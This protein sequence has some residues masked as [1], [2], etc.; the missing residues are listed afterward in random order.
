M[1]SNCTNWTAFHG[2][3]AVFLTLMLN[4]F[5]LFNFCAFSDGFYAA[6]DRTLTHQYLK[7]H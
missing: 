5:F 2:R 6:V 1:A 4:V 7:V 3:Y